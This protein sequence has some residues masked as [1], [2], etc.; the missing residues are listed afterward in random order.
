MKRGGVCCIAQFWVLVECLQARRLAERREFAAGKDMRRMGGGRDG[1]PG[2]IRTCD[3]TLRRR[4]LYPAELRVLKSKNT[5]F[6][7]NL[8]QNWGAVG[9]WDEMEGFCAGS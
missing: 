4:S 6:G 8:L 5:A 3:L 2:K 9:G 1:A 7:Q